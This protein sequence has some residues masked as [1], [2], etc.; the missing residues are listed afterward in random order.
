MKLRV[1]AP[2]SEFT[3]YDLSKDQTIKIGAH[4]SATLQLVGPNIHPIHAG[5]LF[6]NGSYVLAATKT[7]RTIVLNGSPIT[8][9]K[10]G[11][12]DQIA[13]GDF[14][15]ELI[16]PSQ[17][18]TSGAKK[19]IDEDD[20]LLI[21]PPTKTK[22]NQPPEV[23]VVGTS[24]ELEELDEVEALDEVEEFDEIEEFDEVE[25]LDDVEELDEVVAL[26]D[27]EALDE[28]EELDDVQELSSPQNLSDDLGL[29]NE[30]AEDEAPIYDPPSKPSAEEVSVKTR[31]SSSSGRIWRTVGIVLLAMAMGGFGV[32]F[33][34]LSKSERQEYKAANQLFETQNY[35]QAQ[36]ELTS[37]LLKYPNSKVADEAKLK[38]EIAKVS[39]WIGKD[40]TTPDQ[41]FD[42]IQSSCET[43]GELSNHPMF[44]KHVDS[45]LPPAT[46]K[47]GQAALEKIGEESQIIETIRS[48]IAKVAFC[49]NMASSDANLNS[50]ISDVEIRLSTRLIELEKKSEINNF[51]T[52]AQSSDLGQLKMLA[53]QLLSTYP[54]AQTD[55][56]FLL[57]MREAAGAHAPK[58]NSVKPGTLRFNPIENVQSFSIA[59]L[60]SAKK[61]TA[62]EQNRLVFDSHSGMLYAF[63]ESSGAL[64]WSKLIG[65]NGAVCHLPFGVQN[66]NRIVFDAYQNAICNIDPASGKANWSF[67]TSQTPISTTLIGDSVYAT[68]R[69]SFL[70]LD[71]KTGTTKQSYQLTAQPVG[72]TFRSKS[73]PF[74]LQLSTGGYC[75]SFSQQQG[76]ATG[77]CGVGSDV[78]HSISPMG[79][80]FVAASNGVNSTQFNLLSRVNNAISLRQSL[81]VS[82]RAVSDILPVQNVGLVMMDN[83]LIRKLSLS[84][85]PVSP[86]ES[87]VVSSSSND[88]VAESWMIN[89]LGSIWVFGNGIQKYT[90]DR[91]T[92]KLNFERKFLDDCEMIQAPQRY[93]SSAILGCRDRKSGRLFAVSFNMSNSK[94]EWKTEVGFEI[95]LASNNQSSSLHFA[96]PNLTLFDAAN[97]TAQS[98]MSN[99]DS[100]S[101][102]TIQI[103]FDVAANQDFLVASQI[104]QPQLRLKKLSDGSTQSIK[105]LARVIGNP[106][107]VENSLVVPVTGGTL[108]IIDLTSPDSRHRWVPTELSIGKTSSA[109]GSEIELLQVDE[110]VVLISNQKV[111][112]LTLGADD[113]MMLTYG[114]KLQNSITHQFVD[115]NG[116]WCIDS[117]NSLI[118]LDLQTLSVQTET[119]L[120]YSLTN[121][122]S[123]ASDYLVLQKPDSSIQGFNMASGKIA[124]ES[125][126][127][128]SRL[129]SVVEMNDHL[130]LAF[131]SGMLKH[132]NKQSGQ[133][134]G[135]RFIGFLSSKLV[136]Q[137]NRLYAISESG[138]VI[139]LKKISELF[140]DE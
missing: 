118:K 18:G 129:L 43:L 2:N 71:A 114:K 65:V 126:I 62:T 128:E 72:P 87:E 30:W 95:Q 4:S 73:D 125:Q 48:A 112:S 33:S 75:Y 58:A 121:G 67:A 16:D 70:E 139:L 46:A 39:S 124:W 7:S 38:V 28:I 66:T 132:V 77:Y 52:T 23:D 57:A 8:Q 64:A 131:S 5:I 104:G 106:V 54:S 111:A 109:G 29:D 56:E 42:L 61:K 36:S 19:D 3:D 102:S 68:F 119:A 81:R 123:Q 103:S 82:N 84:N 140:A 101:E 96:G 31:S 24:D 51:A 47:I 135:E 25:E 26:D 27:V 79:D 59:L 99:S 55:T 40:S 133:I 108:E 120:G 98:S 100:S 37:F 17:T 49:S 60:E 6:K 10:I 127:D 83:G 45:L 113:S 107:I 44:A 12:G 11:R 21:D 116:L 80:F 63:G 137:N 74:L 13:I 41:T 122:P 89:S 94:I 50:Q 134:M 115:G 117:Q 130:V 69:D 9:S 105:L 53:D 93:S 86:L 34:L 76:A 78:E 136:N 92:S 110:K 35:D 91:R 138:S 15:L 32:A 20:L 97:R 14:L 90:F 1:I 85:N 22:S 88:L